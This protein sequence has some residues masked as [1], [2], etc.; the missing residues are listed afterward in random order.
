MNIET[1][2]KEKTY[3]YRDSQMTM[4]QDKIETNDCKILC[5]GICFDASCP[6]FGN[7]YGCFKV[8]NMPDQVF[9]FIYHIWRPDQ[10]DDY[11]NEMTHIYELIEKNK[12]G[13]TYYDRVHT[14]FGNNA[15]SDYPSYKTFN[16]DDKI[17]KNLM[18]TI[19][20]WSK[21]NDLCGVM[22]K[23]IDK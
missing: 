2:I 9:E 11:T 18:D 14:P 13:V 21:A 16:N 20:A 3:E 5:A 19:T 12:F 7:M 23:E 10:D 22:K 6:L 17:M 15:F 1:L 4:I 8:N